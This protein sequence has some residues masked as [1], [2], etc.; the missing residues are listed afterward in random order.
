[1][2]RIQEG[3]DSRCKTSSLQEITEE[4]HPDKGLIDQRNFGL[5]RAEPNPKDEAQ[6]QPPINVTPPAKGALNKYKVS[7]NISPP[8]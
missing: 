8:K 4:R 2:I 3:S 1:M 5:M 7:E 6:N